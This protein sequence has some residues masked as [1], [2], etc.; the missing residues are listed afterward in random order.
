MVK[1]IDW[2]I[3]RHVVRTRWR[4]HPLDLPRIRDW[5]SFSLDDYKSWTIQTLTHFA[6]IVGMLIKF[7]AR[8]SEVGQVKILLLSFLFVCLFLCVELG[9]W[10][11]SSCWKS[12]KSIN[13]GPRSYRVKLDLYFDAESSADRER[14]RERCRR[15]AIDTFSTLIRGY[16]QTTQILML[17]IPQC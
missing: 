2:L 10:T 12:E 16:P 15:Y 7:W 17:K 1:F 6:G 5:V 3:A 8:A 13:I 9:S 4:L 14:E 11:C